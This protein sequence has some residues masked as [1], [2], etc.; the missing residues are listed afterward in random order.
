MA[1]KRLVIQ[2][3]L[4]EETKYQDVRNYAV[5]VPECLVLKGPEQRLGMLLGS[6]PARPIEIFIRR[7]ASN[8][9]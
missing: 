1:D 5:V 3:V 4:K 9:K 8:T 7:R 2:T 6:A